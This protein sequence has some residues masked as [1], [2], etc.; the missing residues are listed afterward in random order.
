LELTA[1]GNGLFVAEAFCVQEG[2]DDGELAQLRHE[3]YPKSQQSG[4]C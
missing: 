4:L 1:I 3:S 2:W